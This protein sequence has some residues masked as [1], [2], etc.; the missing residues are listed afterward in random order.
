MKGWTG[1]K[2]GFKWESFVRHD[3]IASDKNKKTPHQ[4]CLEELEKLGATL[5]NSLEPAV[6]KWA[7]KISE[8]LNQE[9]RTK[10]IAENWIATQDIAAEKF[11]SLLTAFEE[12]GAPTGQTYRNQQ[13]FTTLNSVHSDF[14]L[15]IKRKYFQKLRS[16]SVSIDLGTDKAGRPQEA[17]SLRSTDTKTGEPDVHSLGY[18][19]VRHANASCSL[20][21][22]FS[23]MLEHGI[24]KEDAKKKLVGVGADGASVNS[25]KYAGVK[26]LLQLSQGDKGTNPQLEYLGWWWVL[27]VVCVN[28]LLELG[29]GDLKKRSRTSKNLMSN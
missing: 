1:N 21:A 29:L 8:S 24:T 19:T 25:G 3:Q 15:F 23:N 27:F 7:H 20:N 5:T 2:N 26:A 10:F 11:A 16:F 13:G 6:K 4:L 17:I 12:A 22:I 18:S 28:H 14:I 9:L